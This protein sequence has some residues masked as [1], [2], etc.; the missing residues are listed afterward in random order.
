MKK[1]VVPYWL[2]VTATGRKPEFFH[3]D[4]E[5]A[6]NEYFLKCLKAKLDPLLKREYTN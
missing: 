6:A 5:V 3:P 4:E 1:H 2:I